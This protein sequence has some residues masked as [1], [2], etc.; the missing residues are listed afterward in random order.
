MR[1]TTTLLLALVA[2]VAGAGA[3]HADTEI[4]APERATPIDADAGVV[5]WNAYD[6]STK[7]FSLVARRDGRI[8]PLATA[9][10]PRPLAP[11]VGTDSRGRPVVV[12]SRCTDPLRVTGCDV[13]LY[14]FSDG[15]ERT[16]SIASR[17]SLDETAPTVWGGRLAWVSRTPGAKRPAVLTRVLASAEPP[18]ELP[19]LP[20]R[21]CS[22]DESGEP[23]CRTVGGGISE[24]ELR[25]SLLAQSA[26]A[27]AY[28]RDAEVRL[29][30]L[31]RRSS[32]RL[33]AAGIGESG[34]RFIGPS[35][36][37]PFLHAYKT[38]FGDPSGCERRAGAFRYR[39]ANGHMELGEDRRQLSGFAV[40]RGAT[41]VSE[42]AES[43]FCELE[44][45]DYPGLT[46][47]AFK[48]GPC[49]V[50][51]REP[52]PQYVPVVRR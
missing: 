17:A 8:E 52:G 25:G 7:T 10:S 11:D 16:L 31:R 19:G 26:L 27:E 21:R 36:D 28:T 32:Q 2:A 39:L 40:D 50:S 34:Q 15:R 12:F 5:V 6:A 44:Q 22:R 14:A 1:S 29:V 4:A 9:P 24:L 35:L 49:P 43:R 41:Y 42:G 48:I 38:C 23:R 3:A 18:R 20:G 30:D 37:G 47:S 45:G 13:H 46:G 33:L 51:L